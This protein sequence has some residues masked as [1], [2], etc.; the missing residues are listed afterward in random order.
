MGGAVALAASGDLLALGRGAPPV[1]QDRV[2]DATVAFYGIWPKSGE[3]SIATP[4]LVHVAEHEEH[5]PPALPGNFPKWFEGM[6]NVEMHIYAGTDHAFF[7][8]THGPDCYD[9]ANARLAWD[10][11]IAFFRR[12]LT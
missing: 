9:E 12:H 7:N 5:N 2:I 1:S 8:D 11:T 6:D 10:R 4:V 3:D